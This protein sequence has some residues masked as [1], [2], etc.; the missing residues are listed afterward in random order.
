MRATLDS[1]SGN[2]SQWCPP[3]SNA[4]EYG[5]NQPGVGSGPAHR[6]EVIS[7]FVAFHLGNQGHGYEEAA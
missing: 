3:I 2:E 6:G 1:F 5:N 7:E 4:S